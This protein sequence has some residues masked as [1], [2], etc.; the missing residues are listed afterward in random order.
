MRLIFYAWHHHVS[1]NQNG[2]RGSNARRAFN[3]PPE[4]SLMPRHKASQPGKPEI[5]TSASVRFACD[6]TTQIHTYIHTTKTVLYKQLH[7]LTINGVFFFVFFYNQLLLTEKTGLDYIIKAQTKRQRVF[8]NGTNFA[9]IRP[10]FN[11]KGDESGFG[12]RCKVKVYNVFW[13]LDICSICF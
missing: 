10:R 2:I 5:K 4:F 9:V 1:V 12:Q 13:C 3:Y 6:F 7:Q 11:R 8:V